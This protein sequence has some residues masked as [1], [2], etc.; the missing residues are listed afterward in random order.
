ME[1]RTDRVV[2]GTCGCYS[3]IFHILTGTHLEWGTMTPEHSRCVAMVEPVKCHYTV[4]LFFF[5]GRISPCRAGWPGIHYLTAGVKG[6]YHHAQSPQ[7]SAQVMVTD[8]QTLLE[9]WA[10]TWLLRAAIT[11]WLLLP[12]TPAAPCPAA[13]LQSPCK[14]VLSRPIPTEM[15]EQTTDWGGSQTQIQ[16]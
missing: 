4:P 12:S 8:L 1:I 2:K 16:V 9:G 3:D 11:P 14:A 15:R 6:M 10:H 13:N 5:K 7:I